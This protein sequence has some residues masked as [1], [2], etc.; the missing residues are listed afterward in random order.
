[1]NL[2]LKFK[3]IEKYPSQADFSQV[4]NADESTVSRI[5]R[6]RRTLDADKQIEWAEVLNSAPADL[7]GKEG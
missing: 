4:V 2:S 5:I 6:G 1:M 3:I 7:F